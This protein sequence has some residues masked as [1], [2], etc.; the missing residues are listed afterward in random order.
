MRKPSREAFVAVVGGGICLL[1]LS[2]AGN[3]SAVPVGSKGP[4]SGP[5][6]DQSASALWVDVAQDA[7]GTVAE[8][9]HMAHTICDGLAN[10]TTEGAMVAAVADGD[11]SRIS[12]TR[13]VIHAAEWH[14][15]PAY[16]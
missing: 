12:T 9:E 4:F 2:T 10:G 14:F 11:A 15:C 1:A 16:Y 5:A 7:P 8:A 13:F 3:A 6:G